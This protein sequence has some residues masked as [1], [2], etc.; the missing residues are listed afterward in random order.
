MVT[1]SQA[2][3][4]SRPLACQCVLLFELKSAAAVVVSGTA[5]TGGTGG[6]VNTLFGGLLLSMLDNGMNVVGI[7]PYFQ[8][9]ISG[10]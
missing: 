5:L 6:P 3:V 8:Q 2:K 9:S 7:D 10:R 4:P 1:D